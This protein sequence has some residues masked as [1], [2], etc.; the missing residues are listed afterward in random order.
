[1]HTYKPTYRCIHM[2]N[3][4]VHNSYTHASINVH[5]YMHTHICS[6]KHTVLEYIRIELIELIYV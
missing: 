2:E 6:N 3:T 4:Y 5:T 1:M